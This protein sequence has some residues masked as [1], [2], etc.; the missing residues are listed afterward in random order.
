[1]R[2]RRRG[3]AVG[4]RS[5]SLRSFFG[6][7]EAPGSLRSERGRTVSTMSWGS[8]SSRREMRPRTR[9]AAFSLI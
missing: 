1:M 9:R 7:S 2:R 4:R 6:G 8:F 3:S 5:Q